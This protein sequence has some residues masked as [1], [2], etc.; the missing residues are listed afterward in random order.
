MQKRK[1]RLLFYLVLLLGVATIYGQ[2]DKSPWSY[3]LGLGV[4][5][6]EIWSA[7]GYVYYKHSYISGAWGGFWRAKLKW[8]T[9]S[10][11]SLGHAIIDQGDYA[12]ELGLTGAYNWFQAP[13]SMAMEINR[14]YGARVLH[15]VQFQ[16]QLNLGPQITARLWGA[17]IQAIWP[18]LQ[19]LD[20]RK[21]FYT[22]WRIGYSWKLFQD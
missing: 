14:L 16:Q 4:G 1:D 13:D 6:P 3:R 9:A 21:D 8:W 2:D 11:L 10:R 7:Q 15:N 18:V 19:I 22:E 5:K 12:L 17:E 20:Q